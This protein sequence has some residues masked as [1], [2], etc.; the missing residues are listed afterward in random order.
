MIKIRTLNL[1]G[2]ELL[3]LNDCLR[4]S[5]LKRLEIIGN[6]IQYLTEKDFLSVLVTGE[7]LLRENQIHKIDTCTFK[8]LNT[9]LQELD[10][11]FNEITSINGS[12]KHL[13]SLR[14]LNLSHNSIQ[15]MTLSLFASSSLSLFLYTCIYMYIDN[16]LN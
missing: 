4:C 3:S 15:V 8:H 16:I 9:S 12:V 11:S 5:Q 7:L 10:L 2:N 14:I 13:S 6:S 1:N